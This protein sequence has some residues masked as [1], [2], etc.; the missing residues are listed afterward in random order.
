MK[1]VLSYL[2]FC[3]IFVSFGRGGRFDSKEEL[4]VSRLKSDPIVKSIFRYQMEKLHA[5][6]VPLSKKEMVAEQMIKEVVSDQLKLGLLPFIIHKKG[7]ESVYFQRERLTRLA[8]VFRDIFKKYND[9]EALVSSLLIK[10]LKNL[11]FETQKELFEEL[12]K[13]LASPIPSLDKFLPK[14][15]QYLAYEM[16]YT[17]IKIVLYESLQAVDFEKPVEEQEEKLRNLND[18]FLPLSEG[19]QKIIGEIL[20]EILAVYDKTMVIEAVKRIFFKYK[21]SPLAVE[22]ILDEIHAKDE[23]KEGVKEFK[24]YIQRYV[25]KILR[26]EGSLIVPRSSFSTMSEKSI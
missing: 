24:E 3:L 23:N 8:L 7:K 11:G 1:R 14:F 20:S 17:S 18:G 2:I 9:R 12:S 25:L 16:T 4:G 5:R 19:A 21:L 26:D 10:G 13:P 6:K 15:H 22:G